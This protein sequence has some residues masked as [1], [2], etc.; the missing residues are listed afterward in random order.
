MLDFPLV[1]SVEGPQ[2]W[3]RNALACSSVSWMRYYHGL[4]CSKS[5]RLFLSFSCDRHL[6][7]Y[8]SCDGFRGFHRPSAT[9][10]ATTVA[11]S[12]TP[13]RHHHLHHLR[14]FRGS[15]PR[16]QALEKWSCNLMLEDA[17]GNFP[18]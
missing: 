11:T 2:S 9:A 17:Y 1:V 12:I 4:M 8:S 16:G 7:S 18:K 3:P 14:R 5:C 13:Q 15:Y 6:S 10:A